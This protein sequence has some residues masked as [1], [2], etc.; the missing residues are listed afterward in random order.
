MAFADYTLKTYTE[1]SKAM[2][3]Y[4]ISFFPTAPMF[5]VEWRFGDAFTPGSELTA[6]EQ[7]IERPVKRA[8][9]AEKPETGMD[10]RAN[11]GA[12]IEQAAVVET[13]SDEVANYENNADDAEVVETVAAEAAADAEDVGSTVAALLYSDPPAEIDDLKVLKGVGPSLEVQ[14]HN[15]GVYKFEQLASFDRAQLE[16][17]DDNLNTVKGRC[18]RDDWSGQAKALLS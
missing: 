12:V 8:V 1:N 17:L 9:A 4:W 7:T 15:L 2:F 13:T 11:D 3:D 16:W 5:G 10:A 14:L 6:T 18:I